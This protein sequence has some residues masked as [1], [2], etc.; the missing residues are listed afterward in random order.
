MTNIS[1]LFQSQQYL[2]TIYYTHSA[3]QAGSSAVKATVPPNKSSARFKPVPTAKVVLRPIRAV[4]VP[5]PRRPISAATARPQSNKLPA[6]PQAA[7][8]ISKPVVSKKM[9][10]SSPLKAGK[11]SLLAQ[12]SNAK[13]QGRSTL[14]TTIQEEKRPQKSLLAAITARKKSPK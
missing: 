14:S 3:P 2:R 6:K 7:Q 4:K 1:N 5:S 11:T 8:K 12:L 9:V 13:H 10:Q